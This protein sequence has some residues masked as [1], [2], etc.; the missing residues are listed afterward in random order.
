MSRSRFGVTR[1]SS[2]LKGH[3]KLTS[4]ECKAVVFVNPTR[5]SA[6]VFATARTERA[7]FHYTYRS[8]VDRDRH[9]ANFFTSCVTS[10]RDKAQRKS[11]RKAEHD[12]LDARQHFTKGDV[13]YNSWGY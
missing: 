1:D 4:K 3:I 7:T 8:A 12:A 13:V 6:A 10:E 11:E 5:L 2:L 9:I